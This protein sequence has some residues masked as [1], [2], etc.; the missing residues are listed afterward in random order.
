[1]ADLW[2]RLS[3]RP[4]SGHPSL[5][6]T[7]RSPKGC[8]G[9]PGEDSRR[10]GWGGCGGAPGAPCTHEARLAVVMVVPSLLTQPACGRL[11]L[12]PWSSPTS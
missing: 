8:A 9:C 1:M 2:G 11:R 5:G 4:S 7:S 6:S 10:V 12:R 3:H